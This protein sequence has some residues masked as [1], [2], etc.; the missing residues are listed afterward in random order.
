M[1]KRDE[2][3]RTAAREF[4]L[5]RLAACRGALASASS[6]L[7]D[8]LILFVETGEDPKGKERSKLLEAVDLAIGEAARAI[9]L[10]MPA[11]GDVDPGEGE[12]ELDL[13]DED[14]DS[15]EDEDE[16]DED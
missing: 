3:E 4:L 15:D 14:D 12:P 6:S 13:D 1:G 5:A 7:D 11:M 10:A 8:A 9:Q 2:S 16:D